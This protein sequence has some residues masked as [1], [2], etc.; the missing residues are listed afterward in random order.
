LAIYWATFLATFLA[1]FSKYWSIFSQSSVHP[2]RNQLIFSQLVN[3]YIE[4]FEKE[5]LE[6][7]YNSKNFFLIKKSVFLK[8]FLVEE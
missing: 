5:D 3:T 7:K 2:E 8:H 4:T 1:S 6:K